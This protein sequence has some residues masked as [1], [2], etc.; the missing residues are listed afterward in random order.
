MMMK[1]LLAR[2]LRGLFVFGS[3]AVVVVASSRNEIA[4]SDVLKKRS[5]G[6]FCGVFNTADKHD[7]M[8][9]LYWMRNNLGKCTTPARTCRRF[10]CINTSGVYVCNDRDQDLIID[11]GVEAPGLADTPA[12]QCCTAAH[13]GISG[14]QFSDD[15]TWNVIIAYADCNHDWDADRPSMGPPDDIWGPNGACLCC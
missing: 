14:Q 8:E 15:G 3:C 4:T 6:L 9:N 1:A 2:A 11:C 13:S 5:G 12:V 7:I 10:S